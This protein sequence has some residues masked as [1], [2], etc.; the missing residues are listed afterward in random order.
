MNRD[1][2]MR[3]NIRIK[4]ITIEETWRQVGDRVF[5]YWRVFGKRQWHKQLTSYHTVPILNWGEH[6]V[7][8]Y[9]RVNK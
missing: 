5:Y 3:D 8:N 9:E 4:Q 6:N 7:K 1:N 2:Q